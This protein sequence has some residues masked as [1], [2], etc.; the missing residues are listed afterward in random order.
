MNP[1]TTQDLLSIPGILALVVLV[2]QLAKA[3]LPS[4]WVPV[5][6]IGLAVIVAVGASVLVGQTSAQ[7]LV[8][9]LLRGLVAALAAVG[10][11]E[12]VRPLGILKTR[13]EQVAAKVRPQG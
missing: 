13:S 3:Y 7:E 4:V 11:F 5:F 2:I 1:I 8:D 6:A 10:T 12:T 9:A